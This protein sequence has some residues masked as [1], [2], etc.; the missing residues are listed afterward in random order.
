MGHCIK[1]ST[2]LFWYLNICPLGFTTGVETNTAASSVTPTASYVGDTEDG[3]RLLT[4]DILHE[5][6]C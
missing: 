1:S 5:T 6:V 2:L 3:C 4:E